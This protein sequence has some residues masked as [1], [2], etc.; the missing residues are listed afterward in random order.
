M[1]R[2]LDLPVTIEVLPTVREPDG[3]ALSSRNQLLSPDQRPQALALHAGLAAA[4]AVVAAGETDAER[5]RAAAMAA[6]AERGVMPEYFALVHPDTL[7]AVPNLNGRTLAAV[8]ARVGP[9]R[10]IDNTILS[11]RS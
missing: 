11:T 1:V 5:I 3:L 7:E 8:A 6:M 10:L 2:D 4:E 9:V